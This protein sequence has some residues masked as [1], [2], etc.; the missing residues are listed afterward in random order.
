LKHYLD[1]SL[2]PPFMVFV[3]QVMRYEFILQTISLRCSGTSPSA[4][5]ALLQILVTISRAHQTSNHRQTEA[6]FC[7]VRAMCWWIVPGST[8]LVRKAI[9]VKQTECEGYQRDV[10]IKVVT[11][12]YSKARRNSNAVSLQLT[13]CWELASYSLCGTEWRPLLYDIR[14][15]TEQCYHRVLMS[16]RKFHSKRFSRL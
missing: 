12:L 13:S 5:S 4:L 15:T 2:H 11:R 8:A 10:R 3:T 16:C 6:F 7:I 9:D 1:S 14:L